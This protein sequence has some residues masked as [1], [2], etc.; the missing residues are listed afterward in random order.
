MYVRFV[1]DDEQYARM[2]FDLDTMVQPYKS[3]LKDHT[4]TL[5]TLDL[6]KL[7][8]VLLQDKKTRISKKLYR[9]K[10]RSFDELTGKVFLYTQHTQ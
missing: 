4:S 7:Y 6:G 10:I 8:V 1:G 5:T 3:M 9:V 2:R